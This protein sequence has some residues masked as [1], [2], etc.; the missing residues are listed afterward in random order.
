VVGAGQLDV[1]RA[2]NVRCHVARPFH[3]RHLVADAMDDQGGNTDG[4][5][6]VADVGAHRHLQQH[7]RAARTDGAAFESRPLAYEALVVGHA[8]REHPR[9]DAGAHSRSICST[10]C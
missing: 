8:G 1:L 3:A 9:G 6:D 5:Q 10:K 2:G 7:A 4:R